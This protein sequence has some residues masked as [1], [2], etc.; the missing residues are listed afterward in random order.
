[1]IDV[2]D[3]VSSGPEPDSVTGQIVVYSSIVSVVT[4]PILAGQFVTVAAH[5]V[6][7]YVVVAKTVEV[8]YCVGDGPVVETAPED[9]S[10]TGQ[11]VV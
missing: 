9:F 11:M 1:M 6:I 5:E 7:V 10:V 4:F 2:V 8:V 3:V